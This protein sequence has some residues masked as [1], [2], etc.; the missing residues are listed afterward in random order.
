MTSPPPRF[1]APARVA[2][3]APPVKARLDR[4]KRQ[5]EDEKQR[6]VTHSEVVDLLLDRWD[7][8][9]AAEPKPI[10]EVH[11]SEVRERKDGR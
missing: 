3:L 4:L 2:N 8:G 5:L 7:A 6:Q 9:P 11:Y 1:A 10:L